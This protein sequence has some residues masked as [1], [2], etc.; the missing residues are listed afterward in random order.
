MNAAAAAGSKNQGSY[1]RGASKP[2]TIASPARRIASAA[3]SSSTTCRT[4]A[5]AGRSSRVRPRLVPGALE[6][7]SHPR[8]VEQLLAPLGKAPWKGQ[9]CTLGTG[10]AWPCLEE[11]VPEM[12]Q[13]NSDIAR[14]LY[15]CWNAREL[16]RAAEVMKDEGE[17]VLVGVDVRL[18][19][20]DGLLELERMWASAFPDGRMAIDRVIASGDCVCMEVCLR[21]AHTGELRW[22]GVEIAPTGR[23]V[24]LHMCDVLEFRDGKV[25]TLRSYFDSASLLQQLGALSELALEARA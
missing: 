7:L 16:E 21:G 23:S 10:A 11:V 13:D 19:G 18:H 8:L 12:A 2:F 3:A 22:P 6:G 5:R 4:M 17:V 25:R 20:P 24:T 14:S 15:E 9:R 1:V